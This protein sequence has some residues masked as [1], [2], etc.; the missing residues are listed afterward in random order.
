MAC[1]GFECNNIIEGLCGGVDKLFCS[2]CDC[3][4]TCDSCRFQYSDNCPLEQEE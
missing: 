1:E 4:Y 2:D 3:S